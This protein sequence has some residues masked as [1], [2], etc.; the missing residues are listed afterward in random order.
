MRPKLAYPTPRATRARVVNSP[1][2]RGLSRVIA[3]VLF[4]LVAIPW[5]RAQS[6]AEYE[7]KAAFLLNFTKF[8]EWTDPEAQRNVPISLCIAGDDPFGRTLDQ[9][10]EGETVNDRKIKVQRVR[11][12]VDANCHVAFFGASHKDLGKVVSTVPSG[13]LTVGEGD[14]FLRDGGMIA[15]VVD[16]RR[17]RFDI[18]MAAIRNS[19]LRV[20]SRLLTVARRVEK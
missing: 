16:N 5:L 7:V 14:A 17:V 4:L 6:A 8:I 18:N 2:L 12:A 3:S 19:G 11:P 13:V 10:V 20:S 1:G 9:V 15:F